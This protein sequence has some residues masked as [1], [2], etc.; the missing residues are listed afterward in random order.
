MKITDA[1]VFVHPN[2]DS[3]VR[4][5]ALEAKTLGFDSIVAIDT[6]PGEYDGITIYSGRYI[7]DRAMRD[8]IARVKQI[9]ATDAVISVQAGDNGFN[10]AVLGL[11]GV[12]ILRGIQS[13]D[14]HG[15]D[16]VAAKM[17]ADNRV[18]IDLDLSVL[19][20]ARGI[21]RQRAIHRYLDILVLEQRFE[22]PLTLSSHARSIL[23][24]RSVREITGLCSLLGMD[25]D[26]AARALGGIGLLETPPPAPV[27]VIP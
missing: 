2:G 25:A 7:R 22:F 19:V 27:R 9:R 16:H 8:V 24:M 10:R 21:A 13:A 15:F 12:H 23:D 3:S 26:D 14:K 17:A 4:R 6:P 5:I 1:A 11:K 18:A 20:S